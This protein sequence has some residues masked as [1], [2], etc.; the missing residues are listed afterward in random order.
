MS[1]YESP[2]FISLLIGTVYVL[3]V[4]ALLL[5]AWSVL[6]SVRMRKAVGPDFFDDKAKGVRWLSWV[7][8][9]VLLATLGLTCL[10]A[11]TSPLSINGQMYCDV[12]WLRVS[13]MLI[14][15]ALILM[16]LAVGCMLFATSGF[17]RKMR[18]R[19]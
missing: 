9:F 4:V 1:F 6:H 3:I 13:D 15:S 14:W 10:L 11:S 12:F 16:L 18:E 2:A 19:K 8:A 7:V 5:V 17:V